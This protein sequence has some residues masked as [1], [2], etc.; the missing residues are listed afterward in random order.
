[1]QR[2]GRCEKKEPN[3][4]SINEK[5]SVCNKQKNFMERLNRRLDKR[6]LVSW[7]IDLR[8]SPKMKQRARD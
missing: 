5:Y 7:L 1:M 4:T 8:K 3:I 2:I 6:E